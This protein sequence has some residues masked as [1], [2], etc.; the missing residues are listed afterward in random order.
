MLCR[1]SSWLCWNNM[2]T[3]VSKTRRSSICDA[4]KS[5]WVELHGSNTWEEDHGAWKKLIIIIISLLKKSTSLRSDKVSI[6]YFSLGTITYKSVLVVWK[7]LVFNWFIAGMQ[8][9]CDIY[10]NKVVGGACKLLKAI[11]PPLTLSIHT[12][13]NLH[14]HE[15][16]I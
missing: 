6:L 15:I 9:E 14:L 5:S 10:N 8:W 4:D 11:S 1:C 3:S 16:V 12:V 7:Q 13:H 2:E